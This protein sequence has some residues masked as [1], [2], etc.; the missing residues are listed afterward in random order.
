MKKLYTLIFLAS[1]IASYAADPTSP[2][3]APTIDASK[4]ISMFSNAYSNVAVNTWRTDW[5]SATLTDVQISGNDVKKYSSL[6]FVG[7]EMVGANSINATN[8]NYFHIDV[9]TSNATTFRV[10]LVDF[11]A[12]NSYGGG[13]DKEH[14]VAFTSPATDKWVSLHIPFSDFT[15]LSTRANLSQLIL[16]ALPTGTAEVFVDNIYFTSENLS[17]AP[18]APTTAAAA[19]TIPA[20]RVISMFSDAYTNVKVTTWRTDWSA[21]TLED[22][23]IDGSAMKKYSSLDFVGVETTGSD[24]INASTMDSVHLDMW[25]PNATTFRIKIVDF[26]ADGAYQG[27]DDT[28]HEVVF[29]SPKQGEWVSLHIPFSDFT[30]LTNRAHIAQ[31]I[32]SALPAGSSTVFIDNLYFSKAAPTGSVGKAAF[33]TINIYPN[34]ANTTLNLY[35]KMANTAITGYSIVSIQGQEMMSSS[36]NSAFLNTSI[37]ITDFAAGIYLLKISTEKGVYTH[38]VLVK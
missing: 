36:V 37:D 29:T 12:D 14:E 13:D 1:S 35:A 6:D 33:E 34:P 17:S 18:T 15:N 7:I 20:S 21:A 4:V 8:M 9:W 3:A 22:V 30:N 31:I 19:P 24:L 11:G 10:K 16:S 2:A 23:T 26:G 32:F 38:Q 27:G 28:E 5:S 25:T